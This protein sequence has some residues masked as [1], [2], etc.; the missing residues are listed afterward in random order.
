M[1][2]SHN[3][4]KTFFIISLVLSV[5][6]LSFSYGVLAHR[7]NLP[8]LPTFRDAYNLLFID[9]TPINPV[10]TAFEHHIQPTRGQGKG[11]VRGAGSTDDLVLLVGYFDDETQAR[12]IDR[13]GAVKQIWS[14]DYFKHFPTKAS[15][16][17]PQ[18]IDP[19]FVDAHG[20]LLTPKG[21]LVF[22][23][24]YCGTV[25]LDRCGKVMWSLSEQTHH[26]IIQAESGGYWT[27]GRS[28]WKAADFPNRF[29]PFSVATNEPKDIEED[30]IILLSESGEVVERHSIPELLL[31]SG[32]LPELTATGISFSDC[33]GVRGELVHSNKV[34]ELT[35]DVADAFPLF[36]P[37]DLAISM[38]QLNL[39]VVIDR[40]DMSVKWHQTGP[41]LRQHDPE[42]R[43]DGRISIFNNNVFRTSYIQKG[44]TNLESPFLTNILAIDPATRE[45]E[46]IFGEQPGQELLSVIRGQH[47]L[48]PNGGMIIAEFDAGRV[49]E[50]DAQGQIVW[51]YVNYFDEEFVAEIT[52]AEVYP[53]S[54]FDNQTPN[55]ESCRH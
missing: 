15:R 36:A 17:C 43:T 16:A 18:L 7:H 3:I 53:L 19:L 28:K 54:Y 29:P 21:E 4:A 11:V 45:V 35:S 14:L 31:K 27:L 41:W 26:S 20:A 40:K 2:H 25:K 46:R 5:L 34:A 23:Y 24:E 6:G 49:I 51:E 8:P 47:E 39:V 9:D 52:N 44:W 22:N 1:L 10:I 38:R 13:A 33:C 12:L 32:L 37:G 55:K 42:F 30:F 48:L 50:V